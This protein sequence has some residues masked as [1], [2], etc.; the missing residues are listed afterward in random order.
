M[1][2]LLLLDPWITAIGA[3]CVLYGFLSEFYVRTVD[4]PSD[5]MSRVRFLRY[6]VPVPRAMFL[7]SIAVSI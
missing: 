1:E 5:T 7:F 2:M 3:A 4:V 6:A